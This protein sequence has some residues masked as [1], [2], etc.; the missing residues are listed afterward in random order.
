MS[1]YTPGPWFI[2]VEREAIRGTYAVSDDFGTLIA[3]VETWDES[4]KEVQEQAQ[5]N[6][7][8]VTAAPDL[9]E[10]CKLA[11]EIAFF[12]QHVSGMIA[13]AEICRKAIAKAEGGKV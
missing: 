12:N 10:A 2:E 5:A 9:L 8:L 4:D 13:L 11:H 1:K 6:A 3:H 7:D